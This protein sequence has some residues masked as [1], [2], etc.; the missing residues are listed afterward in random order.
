M[1]DESDDRRFIS[2][3]SLPSRIPFMLATSHI[4][5]IVLGD[6]RTAAA[7]FVENLGLGTVCSYDRQA[8]RNAVDWITQPDVNLSLRKNA[9]AVAERFSDEGALAWI[10]Q[11]LAQG[12]PLGDRYEQLMPKPKPDLQHLVK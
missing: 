10:W 9:L 2:Q 4:P 3:L 8:F 5:I 1:L 11:S 7:R 6:K 12:K